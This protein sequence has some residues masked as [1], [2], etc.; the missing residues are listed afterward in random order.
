MDKER[1]QHICHL[2]IARSYQIYTKAKLNSWFQ[3]YATRR[4]EETNNVQPTSR[5]S[6]QWFKLTLDANKLKFSRTLLCYVVT[7]QVIHEG[8]QCGGKFS[9]TLLCYAIMWWRNRLF[10]KASNAGVSLVS[11]CYAMLLCGGATGYSRRRA[12]RG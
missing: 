2:C 10:T 7:P 5:I 8:E 12:M 3:G 6:R 11:H 9:L 4:D 1:V